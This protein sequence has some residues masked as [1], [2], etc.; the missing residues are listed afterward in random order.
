VVGL[1]LA[2]GQIANTAAKVLEIYEDL[3]W[4][5]LA[6][7]GKQKLHERFEVGKTIT[8]HPRQSSAVKI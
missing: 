1:E 7:K 5:R 4:P 3:K 2:I 8:K 6:K